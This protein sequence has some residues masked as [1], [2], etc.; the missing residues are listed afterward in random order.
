MSGIKDYIGKPLK[1]NDVLRLARFHRKMDIVEFMEKTNPDEYDLFISDGCSMWPDEWF[2][3]KYDLREACGWHDVRY[4]LGARG[5][6]LRADRELYADVLMVSDP[7]MAATMF[8][9]VRL[10]GWIPG[11]GFQYGYGKVMM[12]GKL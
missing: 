3:G 11:T 1:W 6:R 9:G 12:H 8:R 4:W 2:D 7:A 5:M 10:G